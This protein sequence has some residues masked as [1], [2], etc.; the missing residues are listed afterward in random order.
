MIINIINNNN[1]YLL[2]N[3]LKNKLPIQFRYFEKRSIDNI[4][5]HILTIVGSIDNIPISY[6]HIDNE[7]DTNWI[8]ICVLEEYQN[9]G[10][11]KH[12][13]TYLIDYIKTNNIQNVKLSVDIDNW[14]ALK[15]YIKHGFKIISI[16]DTYYILKLIKSPLLEVSLGEAIDKL[17]ILDIKKQKI[18]DERLAFVEKEYNILYQELQHY[19]LKHKYY[20]DILLDINKTIWEKQDVFRYNN[21]NNNQL[22]IQIIDENDRRFRVKKKINNLCNSELKEQK[23]YQHKKAFVLSHLGLGD[24]INCIGAVR[25]LSTLYDEVYVVC[26]N[27]NRKNIE[28]FYSD[29]PDIKIIS[30]EN[31]NCISPKLGFNYQEFVKI[32]ENMDLYLSGTHLYY[33]N[34]SGFNNLPFNFYTDFGINHNIFWKYFH[35]NIPHK[36]HELY[37]IV[38]DYNI[39]FIHNT[40]S[41]GIVYDIDQII[42]IDKNDYLIIN[43]NINIYNINDP[44][45]SIANIFVN[46]LLTHY[47]DTIIN[48]KYIILSDSSIF[49]LSLQLP[50]KTDNCYYV[51][52]DNR[53]YEHLYFKENGFSDIYNIKKFKKVIINNIY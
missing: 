27:K 36:S 51:S 6:C 33:K 29:D 45:Y 34:H 13:F 49:C 48:S 40:C 24:N 53:N 41:S 39:L 50:I 44:K 1:I 3:F 4:K 18:H 21:Q 32:T 10:Y 37:N 20:Y 5:N 11:G 22:C 46:Q 42:N 43:P 26:K 31:D 28:M 16:N 52:R 7:Q 35:I 8:G 12:L 9:K 25:F 23:G 15:I 17:T 19:I 38:K 14:I 2:E 30:V 47:V